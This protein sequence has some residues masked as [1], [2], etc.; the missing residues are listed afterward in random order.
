MCNERVNKSINLENVVE[1]R[2]KRRRQKSQCEAISGNSVV[3]SNLALISTTGK[4]LSVSPKHVHI[5][6]ITEHP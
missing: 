1:G 2:R 6:E 4:R 5:E 3:D